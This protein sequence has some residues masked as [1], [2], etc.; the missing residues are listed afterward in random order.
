[1][2]CVTAEYRSCGTIKLH[3]GMQIKVDTDDFKL[4]CKSQLW[5]RTSLVNLIV[6]IKKNTENIHNLNLTRNIYHASQGSYTDWTIIICNAYQRTEKRPKKYRACNS[7]RKVWYLRFYSADEMFI[8]AWKRCL[9]VGTG[10]GP[11]W[12]N[13]KKTKKFGRTCI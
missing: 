2:E 6:W 7:I 9:R 13:T 5:E 3:D 12:L 1:M 8:G 11:K 10:F 4:C